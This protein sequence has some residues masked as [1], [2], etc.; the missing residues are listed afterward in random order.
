MDG[1]CGE[2]SGRAGVG[3]VSHRPG[4][5]GT[6]GGGGGLGCAVPRSRRRAGGSG[7]GGHALAAHEVVV[8]LAAARDG[9]AAAPVTSTSAARGRA[10]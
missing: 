7:A 8:G 2:G 5:A 6:P 9:V 1:S 3:N 4:G 10:L